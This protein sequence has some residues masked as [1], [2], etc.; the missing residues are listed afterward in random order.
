MAENEIVISVCHKSFICPHPTLHTFP[1]APQLGYICRRMA[2]HGLMPMGIIVV[3]RWTYL[4]SLSQLQ[5]EI[6][7]P[8][9]V[10][11]RRVLF[12]LL[13]GCSARETAERI[14]RSKRTIE[15]QTDSLKRKFA[16]ERKSELMRKAVAAGWAE[17]SEDV[18][19]PPVPS[20]EEQ[21]VA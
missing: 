11:E 8:L 7:Q 6:A 1:K 5:S 12:Y 3:E 14:G 15:F 16:V 10:A 17:L 18:L 4:K 20:E 2:K 13:R 19:V 9:T 21:A